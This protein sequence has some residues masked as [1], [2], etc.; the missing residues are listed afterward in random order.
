MALA[1]LEG[2]YGGEGAQ[3]VPLA[4]AR[5]EKLIEARLAD[6]L[7]EHQD[8]EQFIRVKVLEPAEGKHLPVDGEFYDGLVDRIMESLSEA[9]FEEA[10]NQGLEDSDEFHVHS[11][12]TG[13]VAT[14]PGNCDYFVGRMRCQHCKAISANDTSTHCETFL[15]DVPNGSTLG[16]G[17]YVGPVDVHKRPDYYQ[18]RHEQEGAD[19]HVLE[20][21]ECAN[22]SQVNWAEVVVR[23]EHVAS[24]WSI[25]LSRDTL[26]RAHLISSECVELASKLSGKQPWELIEADIVSVLLEYL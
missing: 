8:I 19:L 11:V 22:C 6:V 20:G 16:L 10:E 17:D 21:W 1:Y 15:R 2:R 5:L 9:L 26:M 23:D 4:L 18:P 3:V 7:P 24:V 12:L 13:D 14:H 25:K